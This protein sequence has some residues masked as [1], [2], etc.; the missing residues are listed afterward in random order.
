MV[1]PL[2]PTIFEIPF[3]PRKPKGNT[4]C[5]L[6][7]TLNLECCLIVQTTLSFFFFFF[8][9]SLFFWGDWRLVLK[10]KRRGGS[11]DKLRFY[12]LTSLGF[13]IMASCSQMCFKTSLVYIS[14]IFLNSQE[15]FNSWWKGKSCKTGSC[16]P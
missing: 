6:V 8:L 2:L 9:R 1:V 12:R 4:T 16:T 11:K 13:K 14:W 5:L 10:W 3:S 15:F 7:A